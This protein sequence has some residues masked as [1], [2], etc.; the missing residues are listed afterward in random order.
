MEVEID[1]GLVDDEVEVGL[2]LLLLLLLFE[3]GR[4]ILGG[5]EVEVE[6]EVDAAIL[7][8]VALK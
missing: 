4:L 5:A 2:L 3:D 7:V 1:V 8:W 6:V